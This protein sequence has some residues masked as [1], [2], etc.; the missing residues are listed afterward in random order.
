[1]QGGGKD[2]P[3]NAH[4]QYSLYFV[5]I[6]DMMKMMVIVA[7]MMIIVATNKCQ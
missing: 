3:I 6:F 4:G 7:A 1:M 5:M 2:Q